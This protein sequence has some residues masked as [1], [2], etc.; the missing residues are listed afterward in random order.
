[1]AWRKW[2]VR[3]LVFLIVGTAALAFLV[4]QRCT[5]PEAIRQ[6]VLLELGQ[7]FQDTQATLDAARFRL[8]GGIVLQD[9][10][11]SRRDDLD[12]TDF[13]YVPSMLLFHDK[14]QI[15]K[16]EF[17][18]RKVELHRPRVRL[19]RG[20]DGGWNVSGIVAPQTGRAK[21]L[22]MVVL[23][24]GTLLIEDLR[25][26]PGSMPLEIKNIQ[27]TLI[28]DPLPVIT[29]EGS[30]VCEVLGPI[31]I[32]GQMERGDEGGLQMTLEANQIAVGPALVQQLAGRAPELAAHCRQ[33]Q[34]QG[35]LQACVRWDPR[36]Q[37]ALEY[38]VQVRLKDGEFNHAQLPWPLRQIQA[39]LQISDGDIRH[40]E[41]TAVAG[42]TRFR[43][44]LKDLPLG[45][46]LSGSLPE[47]V[48]ELELR[49][50]HIPVND[51]LFQRLPPSL[52]KIRQDY[53]PSGSA[54]V[55]LAFRRQSSGQWSKHWVIQPEKMKATY[56][57]F[58]YP[59]DNIQGTIDMITSGQAPTSETF[60]T[61]A[62]EGLAAAAQTSAARMPEDRLEINLQGEAAG[63]KVFLKGHVQ[64]PENGKE[65]QLDLWGDN[66]PI[67]ETLHDALALRYQ[68]L[69]DS[70]HP[71]G[72]INFKAYIRRLQGV[73]QYSNRYLID[74]HHA[75]VCYDNVPYPLEEVTGTLD[76][77]PDHWEF[78][79]FVG[80]HKGGIIR[81]HARSYPLT[82]PPGGVI[83]R[84]TAPPESSPP[85]EMSSSKGERVVVRVAG[86]NLLLDSEFESA[87]TPGRETLRK[88]WDSF[89]LT[90]RLNFSAVIE[91]LPNQPK[92][93]DLTV[94]I[95]GCQMKPSF[96]P[97]ALADV[98]ATVRYARN[99]V[100]VSK[101]CGR[102][103]A[104]L[105]AVERITCFLKPGGGFWAKLDTLKGTPLVIDQ[106]LLQA[107]PAGL[108]KGC[109][110]L[111]LRDAISLNSVLVID[112]PAESGPPIIYWDGAFAL[113]N[114]SLKV[115]VPLTGV[116]GTFSS[117][118][119]HNGQQ[120]EDVVG[121]LLLEEAKVLNQ[122][123]QQVHA[124]LL[125]YKDTPDTLRLK[126]L[127]ANLFSGQ[128][129]GEA[130]IELGALLRYEVLLRVAQVKLEEF[131][132][133]NFGK[134][135]E[136]SGLAQAALHVTGE[137]ADLNGLKGNGRIDV[138]T[139]KMYRLPLLLDLL[140]WLGLRLPDRTAFEQ[141]H[142]EFGIEGEHVQIKQLDMVGNAISVRGQGQMDLDGSDLNL[143]LYADW[144]RLAQL[145]PQG[146][147]EL[148]RGI[149]NQL[150][151]IKVRGSVGKVRFDQELVPIVIDPLKK[152]WNGM[153]SGS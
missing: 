30:G 38:D 107:L 51:E 85:G 37:P 24:Q 108:R 56:A 2:I 148:S 57:N 96:F 31:Q 12:R 60:A 93:V 8:L 74:F 53:S 19:V 63:T 33:L 70:F 58:A 66:L 81:A 103:G 138:P 86:E 5:T 128:L 104:S 145:L 49:A 1:M 137:G 54:T 35:V 45:Q 9:L 118:G 124:R 52:N 36:H 94:S 61:A 150:L 75:T 87:L 21:P 142:I 119:R 77:L 42:P 106:D 27:L 125:V 113:K 11:L 78:R 131:G 109:Q 46:D 140:K 55:T 91:D 76:I 48:R 26:A 112:A 153:Q 20:R 114:A 116:T 101:L 28:N 130:R 92:D 143:D 99:C 97:Y 62:Q 50:Q 43:A 120:L 83:T 80:K 68:A 29:F 102:H 152:V 115:G 110:G 64:G 67:N 7:T 79:N 25:S 149:S 132:R 127:K 18:L 4:Y 34:G 14:E 59:V 129:G 122:P 65:V 3:G 47:A 41:V 105:L 32:K 146:I 39:S 144:G 134:K 139:G 117:Q 121:N 88:V 133:H 90:G 22:P 98:S 72:R 89:A 95:A 6:R 10:R 69:A 13:A 111:Q 71:T 73:Q 16:G 100:Q 84:V 23:D 126:D 40:A 17:A 44:M 123:L 141:A 15:L 136:M 82:P 135:T 151:R 147:N